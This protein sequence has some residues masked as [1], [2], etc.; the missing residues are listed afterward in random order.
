MPYASS[1]LRSRWCGTAPKAFLTSRKMVSRGSPSPKMRLQSSSTSRSCILQD[2]LERK[3]CW[4]W[5][6]WLVSINWL[7][8][9]ANNLGQADWSVVFRQTLASLLV[10]GDHSPTFP[11]SRELATIEWLLEQ[12]AQRE[13]DRVCT[14]QSQ[15]ALDWGCH[16][17][18]ESLWP[19]AASVCDACSRWIWWCPLS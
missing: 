2:H 17:D 19:S 8:N 5:E 13:S 11:V 14:L 16:L 15:A 3:P 7:Q 9:L 12:H 18:R 1:F 4:C 10:D 6:I